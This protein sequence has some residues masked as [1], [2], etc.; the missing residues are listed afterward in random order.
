MNGLR[1]DERQWLI[2]DD[3]ALGA[4]MRGLE[5]FALHAAGGPLTRHPHQAIRAIGYFM[6]RVSSARVEEM[7]RN[8]GAQRVVVEHLEQIFQW[9]GRQQRG[10]L[11][12]DPTQALDE[13]Y[14]AVFRLDSRAQSA[15]VV[16]P[17]VHRVAV[18]GD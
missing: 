15:G 6:Q 9:L 2:Y 4:V 1:T 10:L 18:R 8:D 3:E 5:A 13:L 12:P 14:A 7:R 16:G 11:T 17:G